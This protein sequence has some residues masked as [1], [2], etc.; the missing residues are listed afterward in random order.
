MKRVFKIILFLVFITGTLFAQKNGLEEQMNNHKKDLSKTNS[1]FDRAVGFMDAG[2]MKVKGVE[3]FGLLSG[4]DHPGYQKWF[5]GAVHGVWGE[6]RWIAPVITMPAGPWGAQNTNGPPLSEDRSHQYNSIESFSAIHRNNSSSFKG[7]GANFTDWEAVDGASEHYHGSFL[8]DGMHMVAT[9]TYNESWPEGY[10]DKNNKWVST[11]GEHHWPGKWA[12]DP[13]PDSPTYKQ[14]ME[15]EFVSNKDIYFLANDKYNG[16]RSTA[17]Y[18]KYGYPVGI[19]MEVSGY[20]Y[21]TTLYKDVVFFNFN[22]IYRTKDEITNPDSKYYDPN[23]HFYDGR[24]D[25]VYFSFFV[26]PDLPGKYVGPNPVSSYTTPWAEDDY[27]LIYD[28]DG[29]GTVD[30]FLAFDKKDSFTDQKVPQQTGDVSAYGINFFKTPKEDPSDP[31]SND[32]GITGFHWIDQDAVMLQT[33]INE[34]FEKTLYAIS[35]GKPELLPESDRDK[36]FHGDDPHIDDVKL[37]KDYQESSSG[38][39]PDIQFWFSSGPFSIA[40]GDTIPIHIGIVGG[41]PNP[42][43]LDDEG[44][45]TNPP[46]VRFKSVFDALSQSNILYKNNF[47]GLRPPAV[48]KLSAKGTLVKDK[49]GIPTIYG[50]SGKVTLY[51]DNTAEES[52]E[53]LAKEK[54][55]QGYRIYR[56]QA[57]ING[58]GEPEWGTPITGYDGKTIIGY[59]PLAQY[60]LVDEWEGTD[61]FNPFFDLGK[62]TGLM[63]K[64]VDN[65]VINGVRYRYTITAYDHPMEYINGVLANQESLESTRGDDPRLIQTVD[66]IPGVQPEGYV[67]GKLDSIAHTSGNATGS[68]AVEVLN[69]IEVTGHTYRVQFKDSSDALSL[70]ILDVDLNEYIVENYKDIPNEETANILEP[71]PRFDGIGL[72]IENHAN[73]E[74]NKQGWTTVVGDTSSYEFSEL[75]FALDNSGVPFDYVVV[76][77]DSSKKFSTLATSTKVPFQVFNVS[78]D[79]NMQNPLELFVKNPSLPWASGEFIYLLEPDVRHRTW[80]FTLSWDATSTPPSAG[81][82]YSYSTKKPFKYNDTY[83]ISTESLVVKSE[84]GDLAKIK[85][86][87]N[88]YMVYNLAEQASDRADQFSHE[89]R[90]THLPEECTIKIYTLR[91][92]LVR[93]LHHQSVTIGEE[94][95]D[96]LTEENMEVSYGV[97]VYTVETPDGK[98]HVGKLAII[99]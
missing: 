76:F 84:E 38:N 27:G 62:N 8:Q 9:S 5:P 17:T 81:D 18:A 35:A 10:Y 21:S 25:S 89:L 12:L 90:F 3:N 41:R 80:Q 88:P 64:F 72:R 94:R 51:W 67:E 77:G 82:Q 69:D 78:E 92:D 43:A 37:L 40:P 34:Q 70:D 93:T 95:W 59:E 1:I 42:G 52:Y 98:H 30:V 63:H 44:F 75:T 2:A 23:R 11:P 31:N 32:I 96:L 65:N 36:W 55:F 66:V 29:N 20:S 24:I 16:I 22:F 33:P 68:L 45:P 46:D 74:Q 49:D 47:I 71:S 58:Q 86:V 57:T 61:P 53:I 14:P 15:G 50:E 13:D 56:T 99:W 79:P 7:D 19:D 97:Y 26:D 91:G 60:D 83:E 4:W 85:V 39:K 87:P 6:V 28:Y 73:L 54:D 48:P